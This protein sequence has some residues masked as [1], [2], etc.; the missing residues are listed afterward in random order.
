MTRLVVGNNNKWEQ[1]VTVWVGAQLNPFTCALG[2][3]LTT[4]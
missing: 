4:L 3:M 2:L 1:M